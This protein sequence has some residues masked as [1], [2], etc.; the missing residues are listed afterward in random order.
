MLHDVVSSVKSSRILLASWAC[1]SIAAWACIRGS[2]SGFSGRFFLVHLRAAPPATQTFLP[3]Y[4]PSFI[5]VLTMSRWAA[6]AHA[7]SRPARART[8]SVLCVT[9]RALFWPPVERSIVEHWMKCASTRSRYP[10]NSLGSRPTCSNIVSMWLTAHKLLSC[11]PA[12][13]FAQG[14]SQLQTTISINHVSR[15]AFPRKKHSQDLYK[16]GF[17]VIKI[18]QQ[19]LKK[20]R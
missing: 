2:P 1:M 20:H 6:S 16:T 12:I 10:L 7:G 17:P 3:A 4:L 13:L 15:L 5:I 11:R 9:L 19:Q 14:R 8:A 18:A